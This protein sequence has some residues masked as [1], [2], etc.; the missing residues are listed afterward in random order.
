MNSIEIAKKEIKCCPSDHKINIPNLKVFSAVLFEAREEIVTQ[1]IAKGSTQKML[2]QRG[3]EPDYFK[4]TYGIPVVEYFIGVVEGTKELGNC[5]IM[6]KFIAYL[7]EKNISA[8]DIFNLCMCLRRS[9]INQLFILNLIKIEKAAET[10]EE[11]SLVFDGNL[12]GVLQTFSDMTREKDK[13]LQEQMIINKQQKQLQTILNLQNSIVCL[14]KNN[15]IVLANRKFFETVGIQNLKLFHAHY[16]KEWGFILNVDYYPAIFRKKDYVQWFDKI[17]EEVK[18]PPVKVTI[19]NHR[20]KKN[21]IFILK[22]SKIPDQQN[23]YIITMTDVTIYEKQMQEL[24]SIAYRDPETGVY[25]KRKFEITLK[26]LVK[27]QKGQLITLDIDQL[28]R[29]QNDY[30]KVLVDELL[31]KVAQF[32]QIEVESNF[33]V[34][35]IDTGTFAL[36]SHLN[37]VENIENCITTMQTKISQLQFYISEEITCSIGTLTIREEES[38]QQVYERLNHLN[39]ALKFSEI[40][41]IIYDIALFE[42]QQMLIEENKQILTAVQEEGKQEQTI[43][44]IATYKEIPVHWELKFLQIED[45]AAIFTIVNDTALLFKAKNVYFKLPNTPQTIEARL[46]TFNSHQKRIHLND[47][48]FVD[49]SLFDRKSVRV[50]PQKDFTVLLHSA[51]QAITGLLQDISQNALTVKTD[52]IEGFSIGSNATADILLAENNKTQKVITEVNIHMFK[53]A[54]RGYY[55]TLILLPDQENESKL[56]SYVSWRQMQIIKELKNLISASR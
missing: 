52:T 9:L 6:Q 27:K 13:K 23:Q 50:K 8:R 41:S 36:I 15:R 24:S 37:E 26:E 43:E 5:P 28:D 30:D 38:Y 42:K 20:T 31:N 11:V 33:S 29:M 3:I 48:H 40:G 25:N 46:I 56:K 2:Q 14:V 45:K 10:L 39:E 34:Y 12:S 7:T 16:P 47:F 32:L 4:T 35:R 54:D 55:V 51:S 22:A 1:W 53:K 44:V 17:L 19:V 18:Q 49:S 21:T